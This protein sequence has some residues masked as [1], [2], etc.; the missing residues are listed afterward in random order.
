MIT[1]GML[2]YSEVQALDLVGPLDVFGAANARRTSNPPYRLFIIG[3]DRNVVCAENGLSIVPAHTIDD[4]PQ[5]D[6]LIIPGA[7]EADA[8]IPIEGCSPGY[9][10]GPRRHDAW[11][12]SAPEPTYWL[13]PGC[14]TG[15]A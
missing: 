5:L 15:G 7:A 8:S 3:L 2:A 12:P 1:V 14:W 10:N 4:A 9:V 13:R 11:P 6:T